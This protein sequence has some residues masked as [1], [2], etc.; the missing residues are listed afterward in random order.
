MD[1]AL[2]V[3][4]YKSQRD[5]VNKY[6]SYFNDKKVKP[7]ETIFDHILDVKVETIF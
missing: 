1:V 7:V 4:W 3:K 2:D 6:I 5:M